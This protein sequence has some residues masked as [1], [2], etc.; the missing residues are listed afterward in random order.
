MSSLSSVFADIKIVDYTG[1][2]FVVTGE[3]KQYRESMRSLG[4]KWNGSLTDKKTGEKFGGWIFPATKKKDVSSWQQ[5]G[6]HL[7]FDSEIS[8]GNIGNTG[9]GYSP[10]RAFSSS[11]SIGGDRQ[12]AI[13]VKTLQTKVDKLTKLVDTQ[14]SQIKKLILALADAQ[15]LE[16]DLE[17]E[18]SD[19][20]EDGAPLP[21]FPKRLLGK[22]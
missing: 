5:K 19:F 1:K 4:G 13:Q 6:K 2:S 14:F 8:V 10:Q 7:T 22:K 18:V 3:T 20:D 11:S 15:C 9:G 16:L 21:L 17:V 12:L